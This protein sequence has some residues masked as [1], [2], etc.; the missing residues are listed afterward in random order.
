MAFIDYKFILILLIILIIVFILAHIEL[1]VNKYFSYCAIPLDNSMVLLP[2]DTGLHDPLYIYNCKKV[3][4]NDLD[5]QL[6]YNQNVY[7]KKKIHEHLASKMSKP[8]LDALKTFRTIPKS[9]LPL[10]SFYS[11][12]NKSSELINAVDPTS[13]NTSSNYNMLTSKR[14]N[15]E[16]FIANDVVYII[17]S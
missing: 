17:K 12:L 2:E 1:S 5:Y 11:S 4:R 6:G 14:D 3:K 15:A 16:A 7:T 13:Y 9:K 8:L 10:H